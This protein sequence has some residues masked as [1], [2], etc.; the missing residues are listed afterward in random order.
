[1]TLVERCAL[2]QYNFEWDT[3]KAQANLQKHKVSFERATTVFMD[4][5]AISIYDEEHSEY[6]ERWITL[7]ID[8][9]GVL[10][11]V[12]HTFEVESK[13]IYRIRIFSTRKATRKERQQYKG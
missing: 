3:K 5:R 2:L 4:S 7:G 12:C 6:E 10:I 11:V 1:M 8:K 9:T 13:G